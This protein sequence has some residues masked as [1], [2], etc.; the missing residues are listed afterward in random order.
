MFFSWQLSFSLIVIS[1]AYTKE[2]GKFLIS[3]GL[4]NIQ[5][6]NFAPQRQETLDSAARPSDE[7][8]WGVSKPQDIR[9]Q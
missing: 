5:I 3:N 4:Q 2:K 7:L 1:V 6:L 9:S 8:F